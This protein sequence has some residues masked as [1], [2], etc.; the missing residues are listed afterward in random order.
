MDEKTPRTHRTLLI[1][2]SILVPVLFLVGWSQASLNLSFIHPRSATATFLLAAVS[3]F[4]FIAFVIFA[5]IL[6]RILLKLNTERRQNQLG[7][8]F[9]TKMVVAFLSL[10]LAPVCF[11]FLFAYGLINRSID[12]WFGIPFDM[13]R[14]DASA[15]T[16]QLSL[17]SQQ[18]ALESAEHLAALE[19]L[20]QRLA[21]RNTTGLTRLLERQAGDL[22]LQSV[23]CLDRAGRLVARVGERELSL[24]R[25]LKVFPA[26]ASGTI[27]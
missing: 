4:V 27:P 13:V 16:A 22:K 9:K 17:E 1:L 18:T 11:M 12:N 19:R 5:L 14:R 10:S 26:V 6:M 24:P 2:L 15:I 20:D 3:A 25:V 23:L 8:H 21:E 7:S